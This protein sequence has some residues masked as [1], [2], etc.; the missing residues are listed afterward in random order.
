MGVY[1]YGLKKLAKSKVVTLPQSGA[2]VTVTHKLEF[3]TK[4]SFDRHGV[5]DANTMAILRRLYAKNN[6][7][8]FIEF[9]GDIYQWDGPAVYWDDSKFHGTIVK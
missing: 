7:Q 5:A 9:D 1:L 2:T 8:E 4:P 6:V 3:K